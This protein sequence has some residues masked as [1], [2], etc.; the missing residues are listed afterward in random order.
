MPACRFRMKLNDLYKLTKSY[1]L[2][3]LSMRK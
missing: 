3:P 1:L 2:M